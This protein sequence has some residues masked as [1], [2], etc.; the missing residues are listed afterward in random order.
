MSTPIFLSDLLVH[1]EQ[2]PDARFFVEDD[3]PVLEDAV[4]ASSIQTG[5]MIAGAGRE[6]RE[7]NTQSQMALAQSL[8]EVVKQAI[9][10]GDRDHSGPAGLA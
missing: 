3:P 2:A 1:R 5:A 8:F 10:A 6:A 9:A 4:A 7:G